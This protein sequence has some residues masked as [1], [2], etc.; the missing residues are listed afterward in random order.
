MSV[1][2]VATLNTT[3]KLLRESELTSVIAQSSILGIEQGE[4]IQQESP[5]NSSRL[6]RGH[7]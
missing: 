4:R 5:L 2:V 3:L 1:F 6:A 7:S